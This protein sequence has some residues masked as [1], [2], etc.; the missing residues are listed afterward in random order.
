MCWLAKYGY[1]ANGT[2]GGRLSTEVLRQVNGTYAT[3]Q[4]AWANDNLGRL[5]N[6]VSSSTLTALNFTNKYVY[7]LA[8]NRLWKTNIVGAV[9]TAT[10]Y[11]YNANDQL[12]VESNGSTSFT[13]R[14]DANGSA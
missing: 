9:T 13:N 2:A 5:T 4:L 8:G 12:L 6:E 14:Y 1:A 7:D 10:S 11:S 3:N